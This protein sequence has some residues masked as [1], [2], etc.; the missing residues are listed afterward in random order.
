[1]KGQRKHYHVLHR[2]MNRD[3]D[4]NYFAKDMEMATDLALREAEM[5]REEGGDVEQI[6]NKEWYIDSGNTTYILEIT[7]CY[8]TDCYKSQPMSKPK[9]W[10]IEEAITS[11]EQ[12]ISN[13]DHS[14]KLKWQKR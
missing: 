10:M 5:D 6:T 1:M 3:P 12:I 8:E 7:D 14:L 2:M 9:G 13:G 4:V 11:V